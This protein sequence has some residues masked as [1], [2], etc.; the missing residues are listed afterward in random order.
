MSAPIGTIPVPRYMIIYSNTGPIG[1]MNLAP[2]NEPNIA[3][4]WPNDPFR[5]WREWVQF[6][7]TFAAGKEI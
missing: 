2:N 1:S 4:A 3:S 5:Y 6:G 7:Y